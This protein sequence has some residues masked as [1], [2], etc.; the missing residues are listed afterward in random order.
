MDVLVNK[1]ESFTVEFWFKSDVINAKNLQCNINTTKSTKPL[2][3]TTNNPGDNN[4]GLN[5]TITGKDKVLLCKND[6]KPCTLEQAM[7]PLFC[8]NVDRKNLTELYC[9]TTTLKAGSK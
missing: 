7:S 3:C 5:A 9:S 8:E 2:T 4:N 1:T 6:K